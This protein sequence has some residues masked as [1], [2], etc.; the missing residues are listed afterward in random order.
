[1]EEMEPLNRLAIINSQISALD[2][3]ITRLFG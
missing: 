3:E 1:M 2:N